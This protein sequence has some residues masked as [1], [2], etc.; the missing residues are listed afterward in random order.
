M[1]R[2]KGGGCIETFA[3]IAHYLNKCPCTYFAFPGSYTESGGGGGVMLVWY[4]HIHFIYDVF[5]SETGLV[6]RLVLYKFCYHTSL[7]YQ[8]S[9]HNVSKCH[10]MSGRNR[11]KL[12]IFYIVKSLYNSE[13]IGHK[14]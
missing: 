6:F 11:V 3:F 2:A 12:D 4:F 5:R 8:H 7:I 1:A 14:K 10:R 9:Y 13:T